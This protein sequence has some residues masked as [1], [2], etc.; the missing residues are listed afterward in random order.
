MRF[1]VAVEITGMTAPFEGNPASRH[2][3]AAFLYIDHD[4]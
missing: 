2:E 1:H 3:V 4:H